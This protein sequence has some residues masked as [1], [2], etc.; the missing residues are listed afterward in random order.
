MQSCTKVKCEKIVNKSDSED[1]ETIT[2]EF[3][4]KENPY[5]TNEVVNLSMKRKG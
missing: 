4:F 5:F 3:T 1:E 2:I